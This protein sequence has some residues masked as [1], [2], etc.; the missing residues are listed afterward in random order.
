[1]LRDLLYFDF[2][3]AASLQS[4]TTDGLHKTTEVSED[5]GKNREAGA[6]FN[7]PGLAE[8]KLG[9]DYA[10]KRSIL[11]SRE[12]HH[13]LLTDLQATLNDKVL[14]RDLV[15]NPPAEPL[16]PESLREAVAQRPYVHVSGTA[17]IE[18]YGR[19]LKMLDNFN[20]VVDF[21]GKCG[22]SPEYKLA[23]A[24]IEAR[25]ADLS[26]ESDRN[27]QTRIKKEIRLLRKQLDHLATSDIDGIP[28]WF[29][30]GL[31]SW[32]EM[33]MPDRINLRIRPY[34]SCRF[35]LSC[36]LKRGCFVDDDLEHML[37]GYGTRPNVPLAVLGLVTSLPP[38][39][40]DSGPKQ[41]DGGTDKEILENNFQQMFRRFEGLESYSRFDRY[42]NVMVHPIAVYRGFES[43]PDLAS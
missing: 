38:Q 11:Q 42:P 31:R 27:E 9:V 29:A 4:Q 16:T 15:V 2:N 32:I 28:E 36:N 26:R 13:N 25:E 19:L 34:E 37:H 22:A 1:M 18:D 14:L 5:S 40:P 24:V 3:K 6:G 23:L 7:I 43:P 41:V 20:E 8:A 35:E 30:A 12:L 39:E 21:I 17:V 33:F 10:E